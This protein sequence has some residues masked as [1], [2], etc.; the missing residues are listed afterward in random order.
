MAM[1]NPSAAAAPFCCSQYG[2]HTNKPCRLS[3]CGLNRRVAPAEVYDQFGLSICQAVAFPQGSL[4][5]V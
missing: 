4:I 3:R 5:S 2:S 1:N